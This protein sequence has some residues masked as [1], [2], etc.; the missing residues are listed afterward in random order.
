MLSA[1]ITSPYTSSWRWPTAALPIRTGA[2]FSYP[3]NHSASHSARRRSP[4]TLYM[5]WTS[6]G[7]PATARCSQARQAAASS[8]YPV[9]SSASSVMVAS[10]SQQY[11]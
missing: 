6:F 1:S 8:V 2:E 3:G 7:S 10:R 5:I 4:V 9:R 11:L